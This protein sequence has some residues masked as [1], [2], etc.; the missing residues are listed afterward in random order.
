VSLDYAPLI[1]RADATGSGVVAHT[2]Q[3]LHELRAAFLDEEGSLV[4][5]SECGPG[6]LVADDLEWALRRMTSPAGEVDEIALAAALDLPSGS[7]TALSLSIDGRRLPLQRLD[8]AE[9]PAH[10]GFVREPQ[11]REGERWSR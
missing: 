1:L 5:D 11:P 9:V 10:F 3:V 2:G 7:P 8:A 4:L 6:L